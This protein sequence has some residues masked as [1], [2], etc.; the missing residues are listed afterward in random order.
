M[1]QTHRTHRTPKRTTGPEE[2]GRSCWDDFEEVLG[3]MNR[4]FRPPSHRTP[5]RDTGAAREAPDPAPG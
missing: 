5:P 2:A 3:Q 1:K 4:L